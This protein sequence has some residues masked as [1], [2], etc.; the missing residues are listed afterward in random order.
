MRWPFK[1]GFYLSDVVTKGGLNGS[2]LVGT[3]FCSCDTSVVFIN[4]PRHMTDDVTRILSLA[5]EQFFLTFYVM[6]DWIACF[7]REKPN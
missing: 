2:H 1:M 5:G 7:R 3:M 4:F 6:G